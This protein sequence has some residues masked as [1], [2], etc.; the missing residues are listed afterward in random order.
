MCLGGAAGV[1]RTARDPLLPRGCFHLGFI[2]DQSDM[3]CRLRGGPP[4]S[5]LLLDAIAGDALQPDGLPIRPITP[6]VGR[7]RPRLS[8]VDARRP[9]TPLAPSPLKSLSSLR[10]TFP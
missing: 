9:G 10:R 4:S 7:D 2:V 8:G 3:N 6:V 5:A 1:K